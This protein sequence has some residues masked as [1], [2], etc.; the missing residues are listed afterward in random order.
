MAI[1]EQIT[2]FGA[3]KGRIERKERYF[4][5]AMDAP[6]M[7]GVVVVPGEFQTKKGEKF[8]GGVALVGAKSPL[9]Q[10]L[11]DR[12]AVR[13]AADTYRKAVNSKL[14]LVPIT[15][16]VKKPKQAKP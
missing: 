16:L 8:V 7:I 14:Q 2:P 9:P 6:A 10:E 5:G 4:P 13:G 11:V 1:V 3:T 12:A 15:E